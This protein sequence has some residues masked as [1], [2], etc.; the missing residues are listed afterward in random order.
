MPDEVVETAPPVPPVTTVLNPLAILNTAIERGYDADKLGKLM[1]LAE[2]WQA[3]EAAKAFATA[4]AGFQGEMPAVVKAK[5][6][7]IKSSKGDF[8]YQ[9][10]GEDDIMD[11]A[12]PLMAKWGI[13]ATFATEMPGPGTVKVT[14]RLR[15]ET[16]FE[17]SSVTIP[18][19]SGVVNN[20]QL[21]G[22]AFTYGRRYAFCN[23]AGITRKNQDKD[24]N[25]LDDYITLEQ[26][27][28][29]NDLMGQCREAGRPVDFPRFLHWLNIESLDKLPAKDFEKASRELKKKAGGGK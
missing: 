20:T 21:M 8:Q 29:L 23:A 2:R 26:T 17:E 28:E 7:I 4:L 3:N 11:I 22:Q 18:I 27:G 9:Y 6:A 25:G 13:V 1:D 12:S 14:C 5:T 15:V 16:H 24:G 19:P 10:A